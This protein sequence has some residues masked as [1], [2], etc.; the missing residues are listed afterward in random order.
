VDTSSDQANC[1]RCGA[2]CRGLCSCQ[3]QNGNGI[4][5]GILGG[6]CN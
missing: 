3:L 1:G 6:S 2:A 5:V 4:C